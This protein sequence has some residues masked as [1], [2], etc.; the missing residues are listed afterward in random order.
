MGTSRLVNHKPQNGFYILTQASLLNRILVSK[1]LRDRVHE[2]TQKDTSHS[3]TQK[4]LATTDLQKIYLAKT[5][6]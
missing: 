6:Q 5:M 3:V 4:N 1:T 2:L